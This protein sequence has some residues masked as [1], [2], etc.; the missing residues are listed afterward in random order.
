M[1]LVS[2]QVTGKSKRGFQTQKIYVQ[3][4]GK[5]QVHDT[6][7]LEQQLADYFSFYGKVIDKKVLENGAINRFQ[8]ALCHHSI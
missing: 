4:F 2:S 7:L 6:Q 5:S 8:R 1:S 3:K